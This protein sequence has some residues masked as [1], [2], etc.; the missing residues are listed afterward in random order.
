MISA[1]RLS[2]VGQKPD[3]FAELITLRQLKAEK[4][5]ISVCQKFS[6]LCLEIKQLEN[7]HVSV[8]KF[9]LPNLHKSSIHVKLC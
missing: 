3:C 8:F 9:S 7:L 6:E 4:G 2:R 1:G 5:E